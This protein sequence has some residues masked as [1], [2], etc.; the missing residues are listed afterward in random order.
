MFYVA[1]YLLPIIFLIFVLFIHF[2][3][4]IFFHQFTGVIITRSV[5]CFL[6]A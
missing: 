2:Y 5:F 4:I 3:L 6:C 1:I